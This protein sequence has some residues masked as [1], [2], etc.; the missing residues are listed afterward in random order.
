MEEALVMKRFDHENVLKLLGI[1]VS[2]NQQPRVVLPF[3]SNGDLLSYIC[4]EHEVCVW[5][6]NRAINTNPNPSL[7]VMLTMQ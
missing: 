4:D 3:M 1:S 6:P 5:Y 7:Y 2:E